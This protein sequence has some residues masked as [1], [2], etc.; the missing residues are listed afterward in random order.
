MKNITN[1]GSRIKKNFVVGASGSLYSNFSI[2]MAGVV[3]VVV[4]F[5]KESV[6]EG[7]TAA[8]GYYLSVAGL[9]GIINV[10]ASEIENLMDKMG[11]EDELNE[12]F[13]VVEE[14]A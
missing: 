9:T 4:G 12:E 5:K 13:V 10:I 2:G 7:A 6:I 1:V 8:Y 3:G 14:E 11:K